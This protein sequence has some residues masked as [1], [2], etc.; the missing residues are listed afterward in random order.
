MPVMRWYDI[1]EMDGQTLPCRLKVWADSFDAAVKKVRALRRGAGRR[2]KPR[3]IVTYRNERSGPMVSN[4][5][6]SLDTMFQLAV[7][8]GK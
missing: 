2:L 1:S 3:Q 8:R 6:A 4:E 7:E 5:P